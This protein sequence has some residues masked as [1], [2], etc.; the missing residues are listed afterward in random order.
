M[1]IPWQ[2]GGAAVEGV[3]EHKSAEQKEEVDAELPSAVGDEAPRYLTD[4]GRQTIMKKHHNKGEDAAHAVE[5]GVSMGARRA[6]RLGPIRAIGMLFQL[7]LNRID[8]AL[9]G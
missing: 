1:K 8:R 6:C 9:A 3:G 5:V 7:E 4:K 2:R